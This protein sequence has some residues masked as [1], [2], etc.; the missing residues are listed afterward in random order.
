MVIGDLAAVQASLEAQLTE[1]SHAANGNGSNGSHSN[2][3]GSAAAAALATA[4]QSIDAA[5][6]VEGFLPPE[7]AGQLETAAQVRWFYGGQQSSVSWD[8]KLTEAEAVAGSRRLWWVGECLQHS[9]LLP[10]CP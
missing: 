9:E 1:G 5:D 2:G 7:E 4:S 6:G 3:N 10:G 8:G